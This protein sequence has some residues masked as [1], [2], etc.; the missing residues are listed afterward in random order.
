MVTRNKAF[1]EIF[2]E[3]GGAWATS[4]L[5]L[6]VFFKPIILHVAEGQPSKDKQSAHSNQSASYV[7]VYVPLCESQLTRCCS[8]FAHACH[9]WR[10]GERSCPRQASHERMLRNGREYSS[11]CQGCS[12]ET[13]NSALDCRNEWLLLIQQSTLRRQMEDFLLWTRRW[14]G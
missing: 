5:I 6:T 13:L 12:R 3:I 11:Q 7:C 10:A 14:E 1:S 2:A 9:Q 8:S 4:A